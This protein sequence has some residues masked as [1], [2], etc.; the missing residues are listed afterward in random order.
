M[1]SAAWVTP[2]SSVSSAAGCARARSAP[3][4]G[5]DLLRARR[6]SARFDLLGGIGVVARGHRRVRREHG[7]RARGGQRE[8]SE[9]PSRSAGAAS[10]SGASAAWP[11]FRWTTPGSIPS[12][13]SARTPPTPSRTYCARRVSGSATYSRAVIQRSSGPFSGQ[14]VSSRN[15]G[16]RPTSTRQIRAVT[17]ASQI[18]TSI[19]SGRRPRPSR[20]RPG[21]ARDRCRSSTR[22]A[23]RRRRSAG[24]SSPGGTSGRRRPAAA[25][26]RTPP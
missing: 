5:S 1:R 2:N 11:S 4:S 7:A 9:S 25:R 18:G 23:S 6:P 14:S 10:S 26:G 16:T 13:R 17:F 22:A 21:A 15:S 8:S 3:R 12:A 24:G 19:V 20:A